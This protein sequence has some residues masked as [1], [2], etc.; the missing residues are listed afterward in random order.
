MGCSNEILVA[1]ADKAAAVRATNA[2]AAEVLRIEAKYSRYQAGSVI[3]QINQS[4]GH[5]STVI[6]DIET[7]KLLNFAGDLFRESDGLF[8]ATSGILRRAW[9]FT[10][11]EVPSRE[12]LDPLLALVGWK[13]VERR[14]GAIRLPIAGMQLDFGGFGKEYAAD[15][16]S[17]VLK[18]AGIAHG[19]VNLGGDFCVAGPQPGG[20]PWLIGVG[21]PRQHGAIVAKVPVTRGAIATSADSVK[22]FEIDGRRYCHILNP[23]TGM[24]VNY[25]AQ[26]TVQ[27]PTAIQAGAITT[28][29]M[30]K[31][32][33]A[34]E[35][36]DNA[37][38]PYLF[39]DL[40]G[41]FHSNQNL[42]QAA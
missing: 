28:I 36:M 18:E 27:A 6:C 35:F 38:T 25:W 4:A 21:N 3:S 1:T 33:A 5:D 8:D 12:Q 19:Y 40:A 34:I 39:V 29:A 16:A 7:N 20:E 30:L 9:D 31:E 32:A 22:Y 13:K 2:A 14:D 26:T 37:S 11:A 15:R 42:A 24:P 10:K 23:K 17:L 41:Q